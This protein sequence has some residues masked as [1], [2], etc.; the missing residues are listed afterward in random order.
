MATIRV[1]PLYL[2]RY[3]TSQVTSSF[4]R[5]HFRF[6]VF[7]VAPFCMK[8]LTDCCEAYVRESK[9][10]RVTEVEGMVPVMFSQ[11]S[12]TLFLIFTLCPNL[13]LSSIFFPST[14]FPFIFLMMYFSSSFPSCAFLSLHFPVN[15]FPVYLCIFLSC[16]FEKR[17]LRKSQRHLWIYYKASK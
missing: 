7:L 12:L 3:L 16:T 6:K 2:S 5:V 4:P 8:F 10:W 1:L 15:S 13:T 14:F 17:W 9:P 11:S